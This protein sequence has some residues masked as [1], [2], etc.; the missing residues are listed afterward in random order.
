MRNPGTESYLLVALF[1]F[2]ALPPRLAAG[3]RPDRCAARVRADAP[4]MV[5]SAIGLEAGLGVPAAVLAEAISLWEGCA[6]YGHGFPHL[7]E[8]GKG[9]LSLHVRIE[10][11]RPGEGRCGTF[12][13][14]KI[15]LFTTV[16]DDRGQLHSC[17][18]AG[19][20]LAHEIGHVLGLADGWSPGRC[21]SHIM[22]PLEAAALDRRRPRR[23]QV[24]EDECRAADDRWLTWEELDDRSTGQRLSSRP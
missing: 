6:G 7:I 16:R 3:G 23:R 20:L 1:V 21:P 19:E 22:S 11:A 4:I 13:R 15:V 18:S 12:G 9:D 24:K 5:G 14:G 8:E 17:G 2:L 10:T